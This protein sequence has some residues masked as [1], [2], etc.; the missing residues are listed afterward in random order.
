MNK[1]SDYLDNDEELSFQQL[2]RLLA[3]SYKMSFSLIP[4]LTFLDILQRIISSFLPLIYSFLTANIVT[5]IISYQDQ[6]ADF[7]LVLRNLFFLVGFYVVRAFLNQFQI[8]LKFTGKELSE[9]RLRRQIYK[10]AHRLG[11]KELEDPRNRDLL[12]V[13]NENMNSILNLSGRFTTTLVTIIVGATSFLVALPYILKISVWI[14]PAIIIPL[15][16]K[17]L[18]YNKLLRKSWQ[19]S[20]DNTAKKREMNLLYSDLVAP[21]RLLEIILTSS[22]KFFSERYENFY[23]D[24]LE[25]LMKLRL[26]RSVVGFIVKS[27]NY[28]VV[29]YFGIQLIKGIDS[30]FTPSNIILQV[31]ALATF[32][33]QIHMFLGMIVALQENSLRV[34]KARRFLQKNSLKVDKKEIKKM[35]KPP[36]IKFNKLSFSYPGSSKKVL[37]DIKLKIKQGDKIAVVGHNGAG[38]TTLMKLLLGIYEPDQGEILLD[39]KQ[40]KE[41]DIEKWHQ[42][43]SILNQDYNTYEYLTVSENIQVGSYDNSLDKERIKQVLKQAEAWDFVQEYDQ[44]LDTVLSEKFEGGIRP[45]TGQWQKIAIARFLYRD[46]PIVI[47]DEPTASIDPVSE[48][49]IFN[50]IFEYLKEKTVIIIS[51]R[52]STVK[53][54]DRIIVLDHG[55]IIEQGTH[56]ELMSFDEVYAEAYSVQAEEYR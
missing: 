37:R 5:V 50:N 46:S 36:I 44:G 24:Y 21:K 38:K 9:Q 31:A 33:S 56:E 54:A 30:G 13:T 39:N 25:N 29:G 41:L 10:R 45:S 22:F 12:Q 51:H 42:N 15:I 49:K 47:F 16:P 35:D 19:Y 23:E 7:S 6:E 4:L 8:I 48:Y 40:L 3:W 53:K 27:L 1:K 14:I 17:V 32:V 55:E 11:V 28:L 20:L 52:F 34:V 2:L 43:I 26:K 18:V